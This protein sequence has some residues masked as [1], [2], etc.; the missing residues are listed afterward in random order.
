MVVLL[1]NWSVIIKKS[2]IL[3]QILLGGLGTL[4]GPL[5]GVVA[6]VS[7]REYLLPLNEWQYVIYGAMIA[8]LVL[9][10][11]GGLVGGLH[12]LWRRVVSRSRPVSL[13]Q[14]TSEVM[15]VSAPDDVERRVGPR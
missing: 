8:V 5:M 11:R 15:V 1:T 13:A 4:W 3:V 14:Q 6:L 12:L 7:L 9:V 10:A 2:L